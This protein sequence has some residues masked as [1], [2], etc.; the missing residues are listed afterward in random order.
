MTLAIVV[1]IEKPWM[2]SPGPFVLAIVLPDQALWSL[3]GGLFSFHAAASEC[4]E[5]SGSSL[6]PSSKVAPVTPE[7]IILLYFLHSIVTH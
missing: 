7:R 1:L 2:S 6:S 3:P 5:G 4:S